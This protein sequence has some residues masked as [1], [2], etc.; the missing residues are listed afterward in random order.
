MVGVGG[1]GMSGIAEVLLSLGYTVSGSDVRKSDVTERL[2]S[3]GAHI[4]Y[5]HVPENIVDCDVVVSSSAIS[6]TNI[7]IQLARQRRIPIVPRAEMLAE[8]MRFKNGIAV[9]GT[10]GKT[11][12]TSLTAAVFAE[13]GLDPTYVVGGMVNNAGTNAKLGEGDYFIA[14]SD[15]SDASFLQLHPVTVVVSN[16]DDDHLTTYSNDVMELRKAFT[17]FANRVPFHGLVV[18]CIDDEGVRDIIPKITRPLITYGFGESAD[19]RAIDVKFDGTT[20][21]FK[22]KYPGEDELFDIELNLPG[23][24][25]VLNAL[26]A[27]TVAL[28]AGISVPNIRESLLH[29]SGISRRFDVKGKVFVEDREVL[30]IDD[31]G[32]HPREIA[33]VIE[34]ARISYPGKRVVMIFQ[35][36]RYSRTK[37]LFEDFASVLSLVDDLILLGIY[38]AG[39]SP[40]P[41]CDSKSLCAAIRQRGRVDP[42]YV[43]NMDEIPSILSSL[44]S[45]SDLLITQ[46]AG[47]INKVSKYLQEELIKPQMVE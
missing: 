8:L 13:A 2:K 40:I 37:W 31:Y 17:T 22:V 6:D 5:S 20:S 9:A 38:S 32:H 46:G 12:I 24:H 44:C 25:N 41:G 28:E 45:R 7:E 36:H 29:F 35:P 18:A 1:S 34:A 33:A 10:H 21:S 26:A 30:L 14:E 23:P 27:I 4:T 42:V 43:E 3:L 11:T 16:I 39:E 47:D 15:E 19:V